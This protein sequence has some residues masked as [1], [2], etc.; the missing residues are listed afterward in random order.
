[1]LVSLSA[2]DTHGIPLVQKAWKIFKLFLVLSILSCL[3]NGALAIFWWYEP[4]PVRFF[5]MILPGIAFSILARFAEN[6]FEKL[7]DQI[8][9]FKPKI[10]KT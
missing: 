7:A 5:M 8:E 6:R 10:K 1:M 9:F 2:K 4:S 3:L